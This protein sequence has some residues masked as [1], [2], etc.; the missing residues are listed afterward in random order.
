MTR[1]NWLSHRIRLLSN[2]VR[3]SKCHADSS[4][5][6]FVVG[7]TIKFK[8]PIEIKEDYRANFK[9]RHGK[10]SIDKFYEIVSANSLTR[11]C[12]RCGQS[13]KTVI[14]YGLV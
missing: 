14:P 9:N 12:T 8:I 7:E 6:V 3:C 11:V 5:A 1:N 10:M 13:R 2:R 4:E